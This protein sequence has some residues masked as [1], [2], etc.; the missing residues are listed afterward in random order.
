MAT[1][2][3]RPFWLEQALRRE[4]PPTPVPLRGE[5]SADVCI[6]GGGYTGLWT[7]IQ[8]KQAAPALKIVLLEQDVCGAGASGRNGGCLLT[9][10]TKFLSLRACYGE[11]E[12]VRLVRASEA[13]VDQIADFCARHAIDAELR[14]D[15]A[16]YVATNRA[17]LSALAQVL[18]ALQ[19]N[20]VNSWQAQDA[21][22]LAQRSGSPAHLEGHFSPAAGSVQPALLARGLAR[23]AR[24]MGV[25][26]REHSPMLAL[27]E[28]NPPRVRCAEGSVTAKRV[29]LALNAWMATLFPRFARSIAVVSSDMVI[30]EPAPEAVAARGPAGGVS[31]CDLRTFVH[32]ARSTPD[33]RIMMGKGGN[34]FP[35][36]NR[37]VPAFDAPS[38][39]T[40]MLADALQR[41]FPAY[42][43]VPIVA[44]WTGPSDRSATGFPFFGRFDHA[45]QILY[46]FGYSGNGVGTCYLG[47]KILASLALDRD[48]EWSRCGFV[49]GPRALFPPEPVRWVGAHMVRNAIRRKECAEDEGRRATWIDQ[50]LSRLAGAA[51]KADKG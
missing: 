28:S 37:M 19:A 12:A 29:V 2:A 35:Y 49:G 13:A 30:T 4:D 26:V 39:L 16:L 41:F 40:P 1:A 24:E 43:G 45:P 47:G 21:A 42:S 11:A 34:L 3:F 20:S 32:Y 27:E 10:A 25:D 46:G 33:G 8:L 15:G 31:V 17:Q 14:R 5:H 38:T 6:V 9:L 44:S 50:R 23:V 51:G 7:A 36:G 48:D 18:S 22:A